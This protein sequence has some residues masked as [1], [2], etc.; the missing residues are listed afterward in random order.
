MSLVNVA[1]TGALAVIFTNC[2][3]G[4]IVSAV[5]HAPAPACL[6]ASGATLCVLSFILFLSL[7]KE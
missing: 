6:F 1:Y 2:V 5:I 4:A 7:A 3:A